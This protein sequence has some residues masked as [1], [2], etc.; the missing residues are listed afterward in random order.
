VKLQDALMQIEDLKM[1]NKK[2]EEQ[3]RV[4]GTGNDSGNQHTLQELHAGEQ[5]LVVGD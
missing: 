5:R 1:K 3:L 4:A 2:S